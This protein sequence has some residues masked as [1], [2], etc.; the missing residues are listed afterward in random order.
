MKIND[1]RVSPYALKRKRLVELLIIKEKLK[2][3]NKGETIEKS[4]YTTIKNLS[5]LFQGSL[6]DSGLLYCRKCYCSFESKDKLEKIHKPLCVDNENVLKV[7]PEKGKN[8]IVKFKNFHTQIIQPFM[9][10]ADFE[11]YTNELNEINPYSFALFTHCIF[12]KEK[13]ELTSFTGKKCLD[14]PSKFSHR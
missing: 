8:N 4:H 6:Y 12:D 1:V 13:N 11:M 10:I 2:D 7:M 9:I 5:R 14:C 3:E